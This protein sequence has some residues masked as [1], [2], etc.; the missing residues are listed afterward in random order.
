[1]LGDGL[2]DVLVDGQE[3]LAGTP[4]HLADEL[5]TESV[6]DTGYGRSG[7]LADEVEIEHALHSSWLHAA[8]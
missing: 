3:S 6:D 5:T 7:T 8:V 4:V 1:M 2:A